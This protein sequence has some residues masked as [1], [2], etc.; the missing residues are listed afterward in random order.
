MVI[1]YIK[2][3]KLQYAKYHVH[4]YQYP[5]LI[6]FLPL[7]KCNHL[8]L[9]QENNPFWKLICSSN[10]NVGSG[11]LCWSFHS[12]R[13]RHIIRQKTKSSLVQMITWRLIS[14]PLIWHWE[15]TSMIFWS[16]Y[17]NFHRWKCIWKCRFQNGSHLVSASVYWH[18]MCIDGQDSVLLIIRLYAD[19]VYFLSKL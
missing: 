13:M 16:K 11:V 5:M 6:W 14:L 18:M 19:V 4:I 2:Q 15:Q 9:P 10:W 12:G 8:N 17:D 7:F 1:C 3:I